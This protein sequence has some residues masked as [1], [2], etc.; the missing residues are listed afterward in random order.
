VPC[1]VHVIL[2]EACYRR[3]ER[4]GGVAAWHEM[5]L[6]RFAGTPAD[7]LLDRLVASPALA[8]PGLIFARARIVEHRG[9]VSQAAV[10]SL[11]PEGAA[12]PSGVPGIYR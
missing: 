2:G 10:L 9:D 6:D 7:E 11:M 12:W 1:T 3:K 5:L 8:G 4:T